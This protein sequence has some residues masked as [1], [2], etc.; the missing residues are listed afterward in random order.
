MGNNKAVFSQELINER[1]ALV[2]KGEENGFVFY[3]GNLY[4]KINSD[5]NL[6]SV[7]DRYI[8]FELDEFYGDNIL[9]YPKFGISTFPAIKGFDFSACFFEF[10][11]F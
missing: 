7:K 9:L 3:N 4:K 11:N 8:S 6:V 2:L 10:Q 5:K 1:Q